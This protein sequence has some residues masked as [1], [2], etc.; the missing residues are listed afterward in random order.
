[1]LA[2]MNTAKA[3][4]T[5][6][7]P[8]CGSGRLLLAARAACASAHGEAAARSIWLYGIELNP[9]MAQVTRM[10]MVLAGAGD[11]AVIATA[12]ALS[13]PIFFDDTGAPARFDVIL[14]NPPFG[15]VAR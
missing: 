3:G 2:E 5:V 11:Q 14:G 1:M 15:A 12:D 6:L 9:E 13:G 8:A 10:N 7:D 4:Q